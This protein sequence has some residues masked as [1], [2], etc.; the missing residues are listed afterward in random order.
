MHFKN[1]QRGWK[2]ARHSTIIILRKHILNGS[3]STFLVGSF[4][5]QL[6]LLTPTGVL[7]L[8]LCPFEGYLWRMSKNCWVC[9]QHAAFLA[10]GSLRNQFNSMTIKNTDVLEILN[11][12]H[13]FQ[14]MFEDCGNCI[15]IS[16]KLVV[17]LD[18]HTHHDGNEEEWK[19]RR[20]RFD[21]IYMDQCQERCSLT[22]Q[23]KKKCVDST[24]NK[25]M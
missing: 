23:I 7:Q 2:C 15:V 25:S 3:M 10:F 16:T 21:R 20:N 18:T 9:A 17:F 24:R 19:L 4:L 12:L 8:N 13:V 22:M 6:W 1:R 11:I 5:S 14:V